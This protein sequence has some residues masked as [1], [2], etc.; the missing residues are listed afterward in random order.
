MTINCTSTLIQKPSISIVMA[1]YNSASYL[2]EAVQSIINQSFGQFELITIDDGSTDGSAELLDQLAKKDNRIRVIH[3]NNQ[4]VGAAT[5]IG[6][7]AATGHYIAI[8][9]SD[10]LAL[11]NRLE[12]Q[13]NFLDAHWDIVGVGGQFLDID[14]EN[15]T[16]GLDFQSTQP[17]IISCCNHAFFSLHHPT[18]MMRRSAIETIGLY[19]ED[20]SCLA[21]D[22]DIF[23]R[24]QAAGFRFANVSQVVIKWRLNPNGLTQSSAIAQTQS[25]HAIRQWGFAQLLNTNPNQARQ[26]ARN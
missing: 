6:I 16:L 21:P 14:T 13:K 10:D 18:T 19:I 22:Y 25:S 26:T 1:V 23:T 20:R 8:M 12:V 4:G 3:Q 15:R 17:E 11:P 2:T 5:N 9:D 24:M 7:K